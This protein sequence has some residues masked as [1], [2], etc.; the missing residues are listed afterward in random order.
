MCESIGCCFIE[1]YFLPSCLKLDVNDS[2]G[3]NKEIEIMRRTYYIC[4]N[5]VWH[6]FY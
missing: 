3:Y 2:F 4:I 1:K 6:V 5:F